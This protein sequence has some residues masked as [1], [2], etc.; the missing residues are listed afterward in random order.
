MIKK[1]SSDSGQVLA[2]QCSGTITQEDVEFVQEDMKQALEQFGEVRMLLHLGD[3]ETPEAEAVWQDLKFT[4]VYMTKMERLAVVGDAAWQEW[5]T[6][7]ADLPSQGKMRFFEK[8]EVPQAWAWIE[9]GV[10]KVE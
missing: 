8:D 7:A 1:L 6:K 4:K 3:L 9:E 2:Y 5:M 10:A